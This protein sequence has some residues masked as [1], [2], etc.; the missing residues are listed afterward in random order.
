MPAYT[1]RQLQDILGKYVEDGGDFLQALQQVLPRLCDMG[2]WRD[3]TEEISLDASLGYVALP[4]DTDAVLAATIDNRPRAV[5]S[6]W[7]DVRIIGRTASVSQYTGVVDDGFHPVAMEMRDVQGE[8]LDAD[9]TPITTLHL[10]RTGSTAYPDFNGSV[11]MTTNALNDGGTIDTE[12]EDTGTVVRLVASDDFDRILSIRYADITAPLDLID[13]NFN[14]KVIATIPPGT[15]VLRV[16]RFRCPTKPEGSQ[17]NFLVKYA[18]PQDLQD[19]TV[20][21]L[22]NIGAIKNGL[23]ALIAEDN[24]DNDRANIHW[25]AAGKILDVEL[26]AIKGA[27]KATLTVVDVGAPGPIQNFY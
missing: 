19:T 16:R 17:A 10:V 18:C 14:T 11:T 5:R 7:H 6:L 3:M 23:L 15:G 4:Y 24:A 1:V 2:T 25:G 20:V 9:V 13:P 26:G 22:G 12:S 8:T 27:A 21:R